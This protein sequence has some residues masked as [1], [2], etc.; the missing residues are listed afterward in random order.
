MRG[1]YK[2]TAKC[3]LPPLGPQINR[4]CLWPG[5]PAPRVGLVDAYVRARVSSSSEISVT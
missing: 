2:E 5:S 1:W 3:S 4:F